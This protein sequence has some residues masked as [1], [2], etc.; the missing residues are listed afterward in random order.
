MK[1]ER[2][3]DPVECLF[4]FI[5][6]SNNNISR[7]KKML[8]TLR[9]QYGDFLFQDSEGSKYFSFPS[10][11]RLAEIDEMELRKYGFGYRAKF[12]VKSAKI[13]Q[14]QLHDYR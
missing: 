6:S 1:K 8:D 12:I 9:E 13:L 10:L 14:V 3:Q 2:R 11:D 4:S 7:I 5:C